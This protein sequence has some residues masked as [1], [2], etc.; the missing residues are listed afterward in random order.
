MSFLSPWFLWGAFGILVPIVIHLLNRF[1]PRRTDWAAM[2]LL[3]RALKLRARQVR[4]EDMILLALRCLAILLLVLALARPALSPSGGGLFGGAGGGAS[5]AG[6]VVA[7]DGSLSMAHSPGGVTR[8]ERAVE[9]ARAVFA[10][11]TPGSPT[12]LILLGAQPRVLYNAGYDADRVAAVLRDAKPLPEPLNVDLG[13]ERVGSILREMKAPAREAYVITDAQAESWQ[14]ISAGAQAAL[15][16]IRELGRGYLV[17]VRPTGVENL[18]VTS[19]RTAS[20]A[21]RKGTIA[22]VE[23]EVTNFGLGPAAQ[24]PVTLSLDGAPV[25]EGVVDRV[26]PGT[27]RSVFLYAPLDRE[28]PAALTAE[29]PPDALEADNIARAVVEVPQATRV[30][31]VSGESADTA[32]AGELFFLIKDLE[33]KG[34]AHEPLEVTRIR[35][36]ELP[37]QRLWSYDIVVLANVPD[38]PAGQVPALYSFVRRGGGLI[39]F[40]GDRVEAEQYNTLLT[41]RQEPILPGRLVAPSDEIEQSNWLDPESLR[42]PLAGVLSPAK[43]KEARFHRYFRFV[44]DPQARALGRL[45]ATGDPIIAE[46]GVGLGKVVLFATSPDRSWTDAQLTPLYFVSLYQ[47]AVYLTRRPHEQPVSVPGPLRLPAPGGTEETSVAY[48]PA[49]G[50]PAPIPVETR[51]GRLEAPVARPGFYAVR[52]GPEGV[53]AANV[54]TDESDVKCLTGDALASAA[55]ALELTLL[56][57]DDDIAATIAEDRVGR[58]LWLPFLLLALAV[59]VVEGYLARRFSSRIAAEGGVA[60]AVSARRTE[61]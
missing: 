47:S 61:L 45:A 57:E 28:G 26:D 49:E 35:Y 55:A 24:V 11:L 52:Y 9:R 18:A 21:L 7:L 2:E 14:S 40:L 36:T 53:V 50:A 17:S 23:A 31:C 37:R 3:R 51:D 43:L 8:F 22:K 19:L 12:A 54:D 46:R 48:L 32:G 15:A 58:Q 10:T 1:R 5:S 34:E 29:V 60:E 59:I 20:G 16:Q 6:V 41:F 44:L 25:Y 39:V 33:V 27:T 38:L 56:T 42:P 30:L 4:L 13:L